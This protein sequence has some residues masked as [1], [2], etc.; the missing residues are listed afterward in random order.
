VSG[1]IPGLGAGASALDAFL[2]DH[3]LSRREPSFFIDD[4]LRRLTQDK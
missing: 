2:V 1:L 4:T 3:L